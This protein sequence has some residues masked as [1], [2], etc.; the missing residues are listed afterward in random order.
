[1]FLYYEDLQNVGLSILQDTCTNKCHSSTIQ[2][3]MIDQI[4]L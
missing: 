1:M 3:S 2:V 4:K